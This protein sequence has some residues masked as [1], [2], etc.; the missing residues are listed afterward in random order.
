M[1]DVITTGQK[2]VPEAALASGY[3]YVHPTLEEALR[4]AFGGK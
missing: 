1:T 4:A 2:V 3:R